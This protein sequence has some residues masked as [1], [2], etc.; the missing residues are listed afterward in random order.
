MLSSDTGLAR[1]ASAAA[2]G[3]VLSLTAVSSAQA[4]NPTC[5]SGYSTAVVHTAGTE[6]FRAKACYGE[7]GDNW[8][9][10]DTYA[11]GWSAEFSYPKNSLSGSNVARDTNGWNNSW[12][13][14]DSEYPENQPLSV[15]LCSIDYS[16]GVIHG[17][18][19]RSGISS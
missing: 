15:T 17:C 9:F 5:P 14:L 18:T 7:S 10:Q 13:T 8:K 16:A 19:A 11:D 1:A 4:A 2:A 6:N 3:I 12:I